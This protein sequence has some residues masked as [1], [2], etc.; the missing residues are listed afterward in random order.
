MQGFSYVLNVL[1]PEAIQL[2]IMN[3]FNLSVLE[4]GYIQEMMV[5]L[6]L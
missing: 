4:V 6:S 5:F 3:M 1:Y 2:I